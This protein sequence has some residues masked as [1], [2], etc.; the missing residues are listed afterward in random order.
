MANFENGCYAKLINLR[1]DKE[2]EIYNAV[3]HRAEYLE[4]G[5]IIENAMM[6]P[7]GTFDLDDERLTPNSR[8]A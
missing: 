5:A 7:D 2:P 1:K 3:F 4:H 8:A 6:Y